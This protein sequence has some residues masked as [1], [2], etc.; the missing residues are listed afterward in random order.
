VFAEDP[1]VAAVALAVDLVPEFDGDDSYPLAALD[2]ATATDKP[3]VVLGN[4]VS[5]IDQQWAGRL[6]A[7]GVPVLEGTRS[8]LRA[9]G[10][11]LAAAEPF[12]APEAV[13]VDAERRR[14]WA[15]R[16]SVGPLRAD[17]GFALLRDYGIPTVDVEVTTSRDTAVAAARRLGYPVV[18]K[19][20]EAVDHKW[21]VGGVRL[22][23]ADAAAVADAYDDLAA[24]LGPRVVVSTTAT[25]VELALGVLIDPLL[26]PMVVV[27]GGGVLVDV[28]ADR[29]VGLPPL[30]DRAARRLVDRLALR[31]VLDGVRGGPAADVGAVRSAI[32]A[33]AQLAVEL[34]EHVV[35][36]DVNPLMAGPAGAVAVDVLINP[37]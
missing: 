21:D 20:A 5:A 32:C 10:H 1:A 22:G 23:L 2:A 33:L 31:P 18:L 15:A 28:M 27:G 36:L 8:G 12:P 9:L 34:G 25:G 19:T 3:V 24:R 35:A 29:A 30:D 14:R 4:M 11:L 7:A 37:A 13:P 26:G 16:L 6:R 17:E